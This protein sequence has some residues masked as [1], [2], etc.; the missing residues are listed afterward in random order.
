M[1]YLESTAKR[2]RNQFPNPFQLDLPLKLLLNAYAE[3][4]NLR[5]RINVFFNLNRLRWRCLRH[6]TRSLF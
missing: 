2:V 6:L 5:S 4:K 3:P 1:L